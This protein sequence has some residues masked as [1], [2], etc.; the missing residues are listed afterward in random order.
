MLAPQ[1]VRTEPIVQKGDR[2][3]FYYDNI[4][5]TDLFLM[6]CLK[7]CHLTSTVEFRLFNV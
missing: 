7:A 5:L 1:F 2:S 4:M 6:T 3:P